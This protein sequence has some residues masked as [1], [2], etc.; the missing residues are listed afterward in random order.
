MDKPRFELDVDGETID[1]YEFLKKLPISDKDKEILVNII[2]ILAGHTTTY[3][4]NVMVRTILGVEE[5]SSEEAIVKSE[6]DEMTE[7]LINELRRS[8]FNII[9]KGSK[10]EGKEEA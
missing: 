10:K 9:L 3:V 4:S 8:L 1:G 6:I 5:N 7:P 2:S